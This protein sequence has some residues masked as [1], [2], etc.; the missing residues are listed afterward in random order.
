VDTSPN[1]LKSLQCPACIKLIV[2]YCNM[3]YSVSQKVSCRY[4]ADC[5]LLQYD[6]QCVTKNETHVILNVLYSCKS[7]AMKLGL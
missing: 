6:L 7:I 3:I 1:L 2:I 4:K 5:Y